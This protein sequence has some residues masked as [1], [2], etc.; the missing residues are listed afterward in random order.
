MGD[1]TGLNAM[2]KLI[3]ISVVLAALAPQAGWAQTPLVG[4]SPDVPVDQGPPAP[5]QLHCPAMVGPAKFK[6]R[7][8]SPDDGTLMQ[9]NSDTLAAIAKGEPWTTLVATE[10][11]EYTG[12]SDAWTLK[13]V[14][15]K[16]PDLGK[17]RFGK[18]QGGKTKPV[19]LGGLAGLTADAP[20]A[21]R[22]QQ[23]FTVKQNA[24]GGVLILVDYPAGQANAV[25]AAI[26]AAAA[27]QPQ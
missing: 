7:P 26:Q 23:L 5:R 14:A 4:R 15:S 8:N 25:G 11:C 13:V 17:T 2:R 1:Q 18:W 9:S 12:P 27:T 3:G 20:P 21:A 22:L 19:T 24:D 10:I 16:N 6:D